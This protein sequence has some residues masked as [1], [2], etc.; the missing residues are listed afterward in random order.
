MLWKKKDCN[1]ESNIWGKV[2]KEGFSKERTPYAC[3]R[4]VGRDIFQAEGLR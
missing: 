3:V 1:R 2:L 4:D